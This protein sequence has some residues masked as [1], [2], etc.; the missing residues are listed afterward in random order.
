MP[1]SGFLLPP[2]EEPPPPGAFGEP[3]EELAE[4]AAPELETL[5]FNGVTALGG[6]PA[7][8]DGVPPFPGADM[9]ELPK[10]I[11]LEG[12]KPACEDGPK[13]PAGPVE[14]LFVPNV[15][16]FAFGEAALLRPEPA[17][18]GLL[19]VPSPLFAGAAC[20]APTGCAPSAGEFEPAVAVGGGL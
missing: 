17:E 12:K 14:P 4:S 1:F 3:P 6:V 10:L 8:F 15:D 16:G 20:A 11:V 9:L 13:P 2:F 18:P 7:A 5:A 19:G